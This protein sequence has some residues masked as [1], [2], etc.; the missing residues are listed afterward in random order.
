M[1]F[2]YFLKMW[3][4]LGGIWDKVSLL[5]R[6]SFDAISIWY[7]KTDTSIFAVTVWQF[8]ITGSLCSCNR[9]V[10]VNARQL[11]SIGLHS[12]SIFGSI[13][14]IALST[15]I[16]LN[17]GQVIWENHSDVPISPLPGRNPYKDYI[18]FLD[19]QKFSHLQSRFVEQL[20]ILPQTNRQIRYF[21][22]ELICMMK[23]SQEISRK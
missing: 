4:V 1:I 11:L 14:D 21:W 7:I 19:W 13:C 15:D 10:Q 3:N 9:W 12:I 20:L 23:S 17:P 16:K 18:W 8:T 5:P 6:V 22:I 2:K